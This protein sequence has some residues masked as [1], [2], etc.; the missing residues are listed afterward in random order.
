MKIKP[1]N[2]GGRPKLDKITVSV[3]L[4]KST[5]AQVRQSAIGNMSA[6]IEQAIL[7]QLAHRK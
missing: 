1:K 6:W 4:S 3:R 2:K 5:V 7:A